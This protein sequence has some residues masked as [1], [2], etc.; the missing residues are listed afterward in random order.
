ML[1][2]KKKKLY[3]VVFAA[4]II[5][6]VSCTRK[7]A[8]QSEMRPFN[9]YQVTNNA[10]LDVLLEQIGD[11]RIVLLGEASHGTSEYYRWRSELSKRLIAEKGFDFIAI[12]GEWA[13]TYRVNRYIKGPQRDSAATVQLLKQYDRWPTWMWANYEFA[14]LVTWLNQNNQS[15]SENEKTGVFGLDVYCL[16]ESMAELRPYL[17]DAHPSLVNKANKLEKCF[18]PFSDD[19]QEYAYAVANA[20]ADCREETTELWQAVNTLKPGAVAENI[21]QFVM[22][23]NALVAKNGEEY[24]RTMI[25]SSSESWNVRDYHMSETLDRL[26]AFHGEG[27]KAIIWEH[28]THVG[29]ARY[30]DMKAAGMINVGQLVREKYG[31]ENV[32]I[33]G[34]GSYEGSVIA[35]N[36]W[37][38]KMEQMKLPAAQSGS[39]EEVLHSNKKGDQIVFSRDLKGE[40]ALQKSIGHRAVGVVYHPR[41]EAG[42]YVPSIIPERYDAFFFIDKTS[43]LHPIP[44]SR[45]NEPPD[46]YPSGY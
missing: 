23:Q 45:R 44:V 11:A 14:E 38:S 8:V 21:D 33:V 6:V 42:N 41:R 46:T 25:A 26:L 36:A 43:A 13:D 17:Q 18:K 10:D 22:E 37:G 16:W 7:N 9:S 24:Y 32:F 30:T 20:T 34:F 28:N 39:W 31:R 5:V 4:A 2:V 35:A 3:A 27:S 12:E 1:S 40:P 19:A 15:R 29:D